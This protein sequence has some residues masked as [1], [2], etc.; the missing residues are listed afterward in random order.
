MAA[1][2]IT[3]AAA[4]IVA[5]EVAIAEGKDKAACVATAPVT[6][7]AINAINTINTINAINVI[8]AIGAP[9]NS[10]ATRSLWM[11]SLRLLRRGLD[12][13]GSPTKISNNVRKMSLSRPISPA[14]MDSDREFGSKVSPVTVLAAPK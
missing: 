14:N 4:I 8:N 12:F 6:I 7:N 1:A 10:P 9:S 3:E 5:A 2:I 13:S 11:A